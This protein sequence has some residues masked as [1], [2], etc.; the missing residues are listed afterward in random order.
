MYYQHSLKSINPI[1]R[2]PSTA[3]TVLRR[4]R[5]RIALC[6]S[7]IGHL[8]HMHPSNA[9]ETYAYIHRHNRTERTA[10]VWYRTAQKQTT[11]KLPIQSQS[12]QHS[13]QRLKEVF[14]A[15]KL[16]TRKIP[17]RYP[18]WFPSAVSVR[19]YR[20]RRAVVHHNHHV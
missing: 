19:W 16:H 5:S 1:N 7:S 9:V 13:S 3:L 15:V 11:I 17:S 20:P 2:T 4:R 6:G 10:S 14:S 12:H 8:A 18:K